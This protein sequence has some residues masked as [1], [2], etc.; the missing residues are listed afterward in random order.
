MF[1]RS[2][3]EER[4]IL[5][6]H[7]ELLSTDA[8]VA[9]TEALYGTSLIEA[10]VIQ[11]RRTTA[12]QQGVQHAYRP[13]LLA[14]LADEFGDATPGRRREL[15]AT[16]REE[17]LDKEVLKNV[18]DNRPVHALLLLADEDADVLGRVLDALE[19]PSSTTEI[20]R[21]LAAEAS[22]QALTQAVTALEPH[23]L[24]VLYKVVARV[25]AGGGRVA[26]PAPNQRLTWIRELTHL[27]PANLQ[28]LTLIRELAEE[29]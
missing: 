3:V 16:R 12:Q 20:L 17:L 6:E 13:W 28:L 5:L 10:Q 7:L 18:R 11:S 22:P 26:L 19:D 14:S 21:E 27:V 24:A 15:L 1:A 4:A 8:D 9:V 2:Y 25:R 23:A 29:P